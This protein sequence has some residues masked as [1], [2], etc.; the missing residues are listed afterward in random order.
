M[1]S[2]GALRIGVLAREA[3]MNPKTIRYY[4]EI[5]LLPK[6]SRTE[7]GYRLYG[8]ET[9]DLLRFIRKAQELG[10]SLSE[11]KELAE[12]RA[13][14]NLPCTH[15]RSLLEAKVA[16]L[17]E[18]IRQMKDLR[19]EMRQTLTDWGDQV[20]G[21]RVSVV[22]PHIEARDIGRAPG[23]SRTGVRERPIKRRRKRSNT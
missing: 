10:L 8:R 15:L 4:E 11:I 5:G 17:G 13:A 12:I 1:R 7:A 18:R 9:V 16:E 21:G 19:N 23:G 3:G 22:C 14:G 20:E 6:P 2:D